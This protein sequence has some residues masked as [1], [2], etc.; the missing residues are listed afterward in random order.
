[1]KNVEEKLIEKLKLQTNELWQTIQEA[2]K[3]NLKVYVGFDD[4]RVCPEIVVT[5]VLFSQGQ[6][7]VL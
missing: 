7:G 4:Y 3:S 2:K 6:F 5:E 1:M